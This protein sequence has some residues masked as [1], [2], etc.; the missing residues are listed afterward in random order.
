MV[1]CPVP[2]SLQI[3]NPAPQPLRLIARV[4]LPWIAQRDIAEQGSALGYSGGMVR[5]SEEP[6]VGLEP[7]NH[8]AQ[9]RAVDPIEITV[10]LAEW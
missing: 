1:S 2:Q 9:V 10:R 8:R 5:M 6:R 4:H 3:D 7:I